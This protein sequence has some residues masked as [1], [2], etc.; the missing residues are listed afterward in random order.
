LPAEVSRVIRLSRFADYGIVIVTQLARQPERQQNAPEIALATGIPQPMAAKVLK[1]LARAE[2]LA[3]HRGAKGGYGLA[4]PAAAVTVAE[5]V[6]AL[7]GPIALTS[8]LEEDGAHDCGIEALCLTRANWQRVNDAI[9]D[10]LGRVTIAEMTQGIPD[11]FLLPEE[12]AA[13][14]AAPHPA[15]V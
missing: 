11:A 5:V 14:S 2:I 15:Q 8:C 1:V 7:D 3:S 10:A 13:A 9:R 6:E 4:R 12:R